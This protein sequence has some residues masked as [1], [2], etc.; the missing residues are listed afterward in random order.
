MLG[1]FL[2]IDYIVV[3]FL[4]LLNSACFMENDG[5]RSKQVGSQASR[6][7]T[8]WLDWIQPVCISVNVVPALKGLKT[9]ATSV[10]TENHK[11]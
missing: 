6:R 5:L 9:K 11:H 1:N 4:K 3:C 10:Q 2:K 7:I 8:R